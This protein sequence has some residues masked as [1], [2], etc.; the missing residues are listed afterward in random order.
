MGNQE[1]KQLEIGSCDVYGRAFEA[2]QR[3]VDLGDEIRTELQQ[4]PH[5]IDIARFDCRLEQLGRRSCQ[6][7]DLSSQL[8]NPYPR[9]ITSWASLRIKS[10]GAGGFGCSARKR[11]IASDLPRQ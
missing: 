1:I 2:E 9:A 3:L 5:L 6:R 11:S 7:F 8:E 10:S 4:Q